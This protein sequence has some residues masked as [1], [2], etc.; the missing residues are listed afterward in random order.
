MTNV[1]NWNNGIDDDGKG[2][3]PLLVEEGTN[4]YTERLGNVEESN[5]PSHV[6]LRWIIRVF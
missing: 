3:Y 4:L 1:D 5:L 2:V 6:E